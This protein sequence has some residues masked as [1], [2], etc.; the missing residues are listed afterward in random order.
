MYLVSFPYLKYLLMQ[1][2]NLF[3]NGA[4]V[5]L[6]VC[7]LILARCVALARAWDYVIDNGFRT[8]YPYMPD[9]R[10]AILHPR[11]LLLWT[12]RQWFNYAQREQNE[13]ANKRAGQS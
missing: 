3:L 6:A 4:V 12:G 10:R 9:V 8:V 11:Y 7:I 1:N 2:L 5:L 13:Q